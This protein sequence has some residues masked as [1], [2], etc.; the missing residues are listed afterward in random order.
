VGWSSSSSMMMAR[1]EREAKERRVLGRPGRLKGR[2]E[3]EAAEAEAAE[4]AAEAAMTAAAEAERAAEEGAEEPLPALPMKKE[5][6][7][8]YS[9]TLR[10]E[11]GSTAPLPMKKEPSTPFSLTLGTEAGSAAEEGESATVSWALASVT[12]ALVG[13]RFSSSP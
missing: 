4:A 3:A 7:P 2:R 8:P 9:L 10:T 11:A 6:S 13:L 12:F 1:E 5:P